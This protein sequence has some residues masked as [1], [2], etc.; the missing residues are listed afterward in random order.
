MFAKSWMKWV[1]VGAVPAMALAAM[2]M[3]GQARTQTTYAAMSV[4][5]P[6]KTASHKK[7]K[8]LTATHKSSKSLTSKHK[9]AKPLAVTHKKTTAHHGL[10]KSSKHSTTKLSKVHKTTM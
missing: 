9:S 7:A 8:S 4:T 1:A 10:T 3:V 2:P 6:A 5:P